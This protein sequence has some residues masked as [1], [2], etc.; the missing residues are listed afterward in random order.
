M[1]C[2]ALPRGF[3]RL[4][5]A[6]LYVGGVGRSTAFVATSTRT[7][8]QRVPMAAGCIGLTTV[9]AWHPGADDSR[10]RQAE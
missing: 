4:C 5:E 9:H 7:I 6:L 2:V 10:H 1:A 3:A 8:L